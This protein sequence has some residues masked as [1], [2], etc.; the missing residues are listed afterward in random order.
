VT[1]NSGYPLDLNLYQ[2]VKGMSAASQI[3]KPEGDILAAADCWDGIPSHGSYGRLL[4]ESDSPSQLL[5]EIRRSTEPV[6]D[7]WQAQIHGKI[8]ERNRVHFFSKNLTNRQI[9]NAFMRPVDTIDEKIR[10]IMTERAGA[11][12]DAFRICVLPQGPLTIPY[13]NKREV[14]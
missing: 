11:G 6:Q 1:G 3:V 14:S 10:E 12:S 13:F 2:A 7:M 4:A 9:C 5:E 8:C